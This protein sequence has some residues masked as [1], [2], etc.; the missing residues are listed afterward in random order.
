[1]AYV[2]GENLEDRVERLGALP[3]DQVLAWLR[4]ICEAV[5]YLHS[6]KR[7]IIHRDIKPGNIIVT[8]DGRPWLV[9]FG[10]AK[11]LQSGSSRKTTRAARAV[12]GGYSPL[13]QY[14][15]GGTDV[16]S[17][18]Y[19]LGA[20]LYHLLTGVCPPE[21]PDIVSGVARL[22]DVRQVN[23]RVSRQTEQAVMKAMRQKPEERFQSVQELLD[24]LPGGS[25]TS[26]SI[27]PAPANK[28]G[29]K[30]KAAPAPAIPDP[31][32]Q[33]TPVAVPAPLA[34][35]QSFAAPM[36]PAATLVGPPA[37]SPPYVPPPW[38]PPT[39]ISGSNAA[40]PQP[41]Q[42]ASTGTQPFITPI[43]MPALPPAKQVQPRRR[44]VVLAGVVSL[45]CG[46]GV[47]ATI[48][49][50]IIYE[51]QPQ[52]FYVTGYTALANPSLLL[53]CVL[54]LVPLGALALFVL[55]IFHWVKT[56]GRILTY[57]LLLVT[58]LLGLTG[59]ISWIIAISSSDMSSILMG[60]FER[61]F[62]M[63]FLLFFIAWATALVQLI[64]RR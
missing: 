21:S 31:P 2:A 42:R 22:P 12:S 16:R 30:G 61:R 37:H 48:V 41:F 8:K 36:Q 59:V 5:A 39:A 17:D 20:T 18:V 14:T 47:I 60:L 45:L 10:I 1:M 13:E 6:Q 49:L 40:A 56:P 54:A 26:A 11:V 33:P 25:A 28:R 44:R 51:N 58:P 63:P 35:Q 38:S 9:D 29:S 62:Y 64:R 53:A 15:R 7:P 55:P 43:P 50:A 34:P 4:P 3:E 57:I 46:L 32:G 52:P 23:S 24:A 27:A 19:A